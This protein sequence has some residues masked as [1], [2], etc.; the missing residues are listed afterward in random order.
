MNNSIVKALFREIS[1]FEQYTFIYFGTGSMNPK[2]R[3]LIDIKQE[4]YVKKLLEKLEESLMI[5]LVIKTE[6][7]EI[8]TTPQVTVAQVNQHQTLKH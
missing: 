2:E 6:N 1:D 7:S 3:A 4:A 8:E 5:T